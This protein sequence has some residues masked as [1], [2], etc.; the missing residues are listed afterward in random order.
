MNITLRL[1]A[2]Y[3]ERVGQGT[4]T[5]ELPTG[6][7][8]GDL[9]REIVRRFPKLIGNPNDLVIAVNQEYCDH[10]HILSDGDEL[11]LIPPVSG[12]I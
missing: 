6:A 10:D 11:A 2:G 1:F 8:A 3:R 4:M 12:G 5:L 7:T 9:A